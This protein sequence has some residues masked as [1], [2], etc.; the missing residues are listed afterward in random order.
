VHGRDYEDDHRHHDRGQFEA[1]AN[2]AECQGS[3]ELRRRTW[4]KNGH[5]GQRAIY[6]TL[7]KAAEDPHVDN[8][9][10]CG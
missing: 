5:T 6:T 10:A 9:G 2:S 4:S 8:E 1:E 7:A 3:A